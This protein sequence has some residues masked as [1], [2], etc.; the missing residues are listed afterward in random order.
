MSISCIQ[1]QC[2]VLHVHYTLYLLTY[3]L[4]TSYILLTYF[5]HTS[6]YFLHT[7][8]ILLHTSYILLTYF[9]ILL[10][11]FLHPSTYSL[12][13]SYILITYFIYT[14]YIHLNGSDLNR[15]SCK[16]DSYKVLVFLTFLSFHISRYIPFL[17]PIQRGCQR[18]P[19]M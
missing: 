3:F 14:S 18:Y 6:T 7:S 19:L 1:S 2:N 8:Y 4:H 16:K 10:T 12:H 13:T 9:Y 17:Y 11:Y 15:L 5:L